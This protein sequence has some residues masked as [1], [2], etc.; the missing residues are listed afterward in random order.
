[1]TTAWRTVAAVALTAVV[2]ACSDTPDASLTL[3]ESQGTPAPTVSP[4]DVRTEAS[5][6]ATSSTSEVAPVSPEPEPSPSPT[7]V[8]ASEASEPPDWYRQRQLPLTDTGFP[9]PQETPPEYVDRRIITVDHLPPPPND[10]YA[11]T[12]QPIPDEIV[13]ISTWEEG[14]PTTLDELRYLTVSYWGFDELHHTGELIVHRDVAEDMVWVFEQLHAARF[15]ME[16]VGL[17]DDEDFQEF[18]RKGDD[19]L[20]AAYH[21]RAS[22]GSTRWSQHAYGKAIDI[23]PFHNPYLKDTDEGRVVLPAYAT[24]YLDRTRDVP[25]MITEGDVVVEAFDAIGWGWGGRWNSLKDWQHFSV[26]GT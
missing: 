13:P 8:P 14:C 18:H 3:P 19:N 16:Q 2:V 25:G 15:P 26:S 5:D 22:T 17:L 11:A 10:E 21:C 9:A 4:D 1:M 20:T 7:R 23:N 6:D 12:I 24:A